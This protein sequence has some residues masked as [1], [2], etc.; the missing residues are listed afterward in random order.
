MVTEKKSYHELA[1]WEVISRILDC[2][3]LKK[4]NT[5]PRISKATGFSYTAV[6]NT[7]DELI[8]YGVLKE[9]RIYSKRKRGRPPQ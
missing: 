4:N 6:K 9:E 8:S 2:I 5:I 7:I 1:K 3:S